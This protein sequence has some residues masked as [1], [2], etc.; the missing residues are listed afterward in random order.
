MKDRRAQA[1]HEPEQQGR[2]R[3]RSQVDDVFDEREAGADC[4]AMYCGVDGKADAT[5][6]D[7]GDEERG[8]QRFFRQWR[9][10]A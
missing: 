10:V 8:F 5:T 6:R 2:V 3:K 1:A 4:E 7:E 9:E